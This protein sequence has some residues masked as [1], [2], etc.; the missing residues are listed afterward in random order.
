M[1]GHRDFRCS[2]TSQFDAV[3]ITDDVRKAISESGIR[4][5]TA[6]VFSP[7][8]TCCVVLASSPADAAETIEEV[9]NEVAPRDLHY[10]HDA[11]SSEPPNAW[12]HITHMFAGSPS[13]CI[14]VAEGDVVLDDDQRVVLLELDRP[15]P[16]RYSVHVIGE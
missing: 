10:T 8:T 7:H 13:E 14:P 11:Y 2:T 5:G 15:R 16:R 9:M 12:S 1:I 6:L 3:D 4:E